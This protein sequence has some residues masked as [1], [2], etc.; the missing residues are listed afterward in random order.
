VPDDDH[1]GSVLVR[2]L[3]EKRRRVED[4][5]TLLRAISDAM[6]GGEARDQAHAPPPRGRARDRS[7][8]SELR[9]KL[10]EAKLPATIRGFHDCRINER[11][12]PCLHR[13]PS[14]AAVLVRS[15]GLWLCSAR[16]GLREALDEDHLV[17]PVDAEERR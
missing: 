3:R 15:D 12:R 5:P 17:Q 13:K 8:H 4:G 10:N 14:T 6:L 7:V 2:D 1:V 9:W 16:P 11:L